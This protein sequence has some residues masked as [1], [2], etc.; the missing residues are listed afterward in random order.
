MPFP[1]TDPCWLD[2]R[3]LLKQH[4]QPTDAILAPIDFLEI[5]PAQVFP[6]NVTSTLP[7]DQFDWVVLH[8][9]M[10]A[11]VDVSFTAAVV[12]QLQPVFAN[13]VFVVYAPQAIPEL[14]PPDPSDVK[15]LLIEAEQSRV[16]FQDRLVPA[17]AA[18]VTTYN[19]S[20][21]LA[22]SLPSMA[23]LQIP[24]LLVDNG[25]DE[26]HSAANQ[27][28]AAQYGVAYLKLPDHQPL[29]AAL[30]TGISHWLADRQ[31]QWISVFQDNVQVQPDLLAVLALMQPPQYYP[32]LTGY[33]AA[34]HASVA[35]QLIGGKSVQLKLSTSDVHL[36]ASRSYW[37]SVLPIPTLYSEAAFQ[38]GQNSD[39]DWWVT[40]WSP[41]SVVKRGGHVVCVPNLVTVLEVPPVQLASP[42]ADP[43]PTVDA[44][45]VQATDLSGVKVL[46]D[47]YNLQLTKGTGIK[48][49]GLSLIEGLDRLNAKVD[50]LLSRG[51]YRSNPILDEVFFFDNPSDKQDW[52]T[53]G[54][55]ILKSASPFYRAKRR[56]SFAGLVVK[57]GKYT[58][59]F[60]KYATSFNLPQCYDLANGLY[61]KLNLTT[62]ISI[63]EKSTSGTPPIRCRSTCGVRR[64]SPRFT[65]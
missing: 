20:A 29:S 31:I 49:Y 59:D 21:M 26:T 40:A 52:L 60:L 5:F 46:V 6:Y 14:P 33:D 63:A 30:N 22:R 25:S 57:K 8:K 41:N 17:C 50:I 12:Q 48:T 27:K 45:S 42:H 2:V 37:E 10:V 62:N 65:T 36:H 4:L 58:D 53:I 55:W 38:A 1:E 19:N 24:T 7:V 32:L 54:K 28:L 9:A 64:K 18:V 3:D 13:A 15:A 34:E 16:N 51:G 39:A 43:R 56:K 11:D 44:G 47:G 35:T 23:A 61:S